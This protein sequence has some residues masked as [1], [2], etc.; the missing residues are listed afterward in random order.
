MR[1]RRFARTGPNGTDHSELF[2]LLVGPSVALFAILLGVIILH[3]RG[4]TVR[5]WDA[6]EFF[7]ACYASGIAISLFLERHRSYPKEHALLEMLIG[8][9]ALGVSSVFLRDFA[10]SRTWMDLRIG[11]YSAISGAIIITPRRTDWMRA[12]P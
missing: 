8:L 12:L 9:V 2:P 5:W 3:S 6:A 4:A 1:T 7:A 11:L 10:S